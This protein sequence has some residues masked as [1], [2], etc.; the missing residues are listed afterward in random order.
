MP[1]MGLHCHLA[2]PQ[3][4]AAALEHLLDCSRSRPWRK[5]LSKQLHSV[6]RQSA[7]CWRLSTTRKRLLS[8][9][10]LRAWRPVLQQQL[11]RLPRRGRSVDLQTTCCVGMVSSK[12]RPSM[13]PLVLLFVRYTQEMFSKPLSPQSSHDLICERIDAVM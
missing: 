7:K 2:C 4:G 10:Q 13:S 9:K 1:G 12:D 11:C 8:W 5:L 6:W 3:V